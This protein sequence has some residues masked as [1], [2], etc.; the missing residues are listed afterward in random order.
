METI[1]VA[2]LGRCG[3]SLVMQMLAAG[4]VT[5]T[6]EYPA[7]ED[8]RVNLPE[9]SELWIGE[10]RGKGVKILDP[11]HASSLPSMSARIIWVIRNGR[12]QALS[13]S[14]FWHL[15]AGLPRADRRQLRALEANLRRDRGTCVGIFLQKG[16]PVLPLRF[17]DLLAAPLSAAKQIVA[18]IGAG[19]AP[20]MADV[21]R[22][23]GPECY[24]GLLEVELYKQLGNDIREVK[25]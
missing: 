3:S 11:H 19:D 17:E 14:K 2:G 6:G 10:W 12:Q 24:Q 20:A 8:E 22:P 13:V 25:G 16:F 18:F 9:A 1:L 21:V 23:R 15:M 7:F 5:V 4:G